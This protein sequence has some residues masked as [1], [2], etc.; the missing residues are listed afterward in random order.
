[1]TESDCKQDEG[2]VRR[3]GLVCFAFCFARNAG[4]LA[5]GVAVMGVALT[6]HDLLLTPSLFLPIALGIGGMLAARK[7]AAS[8]SSPTEKGEPWS[9]A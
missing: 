6:S 2:V 5:L 8:K 3:K 1:M 9:F 4:D 7:V